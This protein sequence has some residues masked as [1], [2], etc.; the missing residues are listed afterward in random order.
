MNITLKCLSSLLIAL[1]SFYFKVYFLREIYKI[2][3]YE[4]FFFLKMKIC[5]QNQ[6]F[7]LVSQL[8]RSRHNRVG[9]LLFVS[10]SCRTGVARV[11]LMFLT[12]HFVA[13]ALH[14]RCLF[15][16][17]VVRVWHSCYKIDFR[18]WFKLTLT[19][20]ISKNNE[21]GIIGLYFRTIFKRSDKKN[22]NIFILGIPHKFC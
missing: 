22:Y 4:F 13:L 3:D 18:E 7:T 9:L 14:L 21:I 1:H 6:N 15:C 17:R 5:Y 2:K 11:A 8:C 20:C 10:H 19:W 12:I 16:T